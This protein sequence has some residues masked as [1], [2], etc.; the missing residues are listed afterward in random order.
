M[1]VKASSR[2]SDRTHVRINILNDELSH[3][4]H[5][6]RMIHKLFVSRGVLARSI[7]SLRCE[8]G[9]FIEGDYIVSVSVKITT[10]T[11]RRQWAFTW[12]ED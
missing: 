2:Y 4:D 12:S 7:C 1:S 8:A 6:A 9:A 5:C 11:A 3:V 10:P